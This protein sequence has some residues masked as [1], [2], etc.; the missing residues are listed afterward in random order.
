[1]SIKKGERSDSKLK[2][3]PQNTPLPTRKKNRENSEDE[4]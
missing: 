4:I 3:L 1:M 2:E